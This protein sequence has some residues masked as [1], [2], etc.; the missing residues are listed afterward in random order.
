MLTGDFPPGR[1]HW[2]IP[3]HRVWPSNCD[4]VVLEHPHEVV[5]LAFSIQLCLIW[6]LAVSVARVSVDLC[7]YTRFSTHHLIQL[8][9]PN[10]YF[11]ECVPFGC[12]IH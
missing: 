1:D 7:F 8:R 2:Q 9:T 10:Y 12:R 4:L 11:L 3:G 5:E 6:S